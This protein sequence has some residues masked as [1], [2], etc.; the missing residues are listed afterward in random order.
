MTVVHRNT[1]TNYDCDVRLPYLYANAMFFSALW[2]IGIHRGSTAVD[3][4]SLALNHHDLRKL[5]N[6]T[7]V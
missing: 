5:P 6:A 4:A 7:A 1:Y 2:Q 3:L